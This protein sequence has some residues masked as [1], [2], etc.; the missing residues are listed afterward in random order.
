MKEFKI[1]KEE[2][3]IVYKPLLDSDTE[4]VWEAIDFIYFPK[5]KKMIGGEL[6]KN[7]L[8]LHSLSS[9]NFVK[10]VQSAKGVIFAAK[11]NNLETAQQ[12]SLQWL[13]AY[14]LYR[15]LSI[16]GVVENGAFHIIG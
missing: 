10:K 11:V 1:I 4:Q 5:T 3:G 12:L 14:P 9:K 6:S 8:T 15:S 13:S 2:E 16:I 7:K